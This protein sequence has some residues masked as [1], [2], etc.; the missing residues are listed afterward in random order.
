MPGIRFNAFRLD[1]G[2]YVEL[3]ARRMVDG[4]FMAQPS[5]GDAE[6]VEVP[7]D[8]YRSVRSAVLDISDLSLEGSRR[9]L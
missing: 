7:T 8:D 6:W 9:V 4:L 1:Y 3:M 5:E 2:C